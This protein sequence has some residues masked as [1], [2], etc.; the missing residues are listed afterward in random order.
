MESP[1]MR[2]FSSVSTL[3]P[4]FT[5]ILGIPTFWHIS[6]SDH[7]SKVVPIIIMVAG[8]V[9]I[10]AWT[11]TVGDRRRDTKSADGK[12]VINPAHG[13]YDPETGESSPLYLDP[14]AKLAGKVKWVVR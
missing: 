3:P 13:S 4:I 7:G 8:Y 6:W 9:I 5:I 10:F 12:D 1:S 2:W 14:V 11:V